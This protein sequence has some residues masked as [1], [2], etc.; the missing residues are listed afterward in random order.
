VYL[1]SVGLLQ[2][3]VTSFAGPV[4]YDLVYARLNDGLTIITAP[5]QSLTLALD[6]VTYAPG[7]TATARLTMRNTQAKP[8]RLTFPSGQ[9]YDVAIRNDAGEVVYRW[10]EGR[11]FT[12]IFGTLELSGERT[13]LI[14]FPVPRKAGTY[15]VEAWLATSSPSPKGHVGIEVK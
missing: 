9:Q 1:P 12:M 4:V 10:S 3:T 11:A 7:A 13:W 14:E 15:Q 5:E 6:E 2:R 8:L